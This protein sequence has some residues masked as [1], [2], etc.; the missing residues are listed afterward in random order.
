MMGIPMGINSLTHVNTHTDN[1]SM[2]TLVGVGVGM[3]KNPHGLPMLFPM[4]IS[5]R[6]ALNQKHGFTMNV[7][8]HCHQI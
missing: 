6:I 1:M 5:I 8:E 2:G 3:A 7:H 4:T